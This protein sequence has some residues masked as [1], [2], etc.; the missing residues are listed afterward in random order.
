M[1]LPDARATANAPASPDA[2]A[3]GRSS[4]NSAHTACLTSPLRDVSSESLT[5]SARAVDRRIL[6]FSVLLD[7]L[8]SAP[9]V[10]QASWN[11]LEG[12][13]PAPLPC[14]SRDRLALSPIDFAAPEGRFNSRHSPSHVATS[15]SFAAHFQRPS[16]PFWALTKV[17]FRTDSAIELDCGYRSSLFTSGCARWSGASPPPT[18]RELQPHAIRQNPSASRPTRGSRRL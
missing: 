3:I 1:A 4:P 14:T 15:S 13:V 7:C 11:A 6:G 8:Q 10:L 16:L 18:Q 9:A 2:A 12:D 17:V 5:F